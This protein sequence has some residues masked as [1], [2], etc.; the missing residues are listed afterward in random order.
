M[1][2]AKGYKMIVKYQQE[3][4]NKSKDLKK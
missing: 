3:R 2:S 4:I 1:A